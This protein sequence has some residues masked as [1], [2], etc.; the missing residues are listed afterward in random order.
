MPCFCFCGFFHVC[1]LSAEIALAFALAAGRSATAGG[2]D[3]G[4]TAPAGECPVPPA[5]GG[6]GGE[7]SSGRRRKKSGAFS[8]PLKKLCLFIRQELRILAEA[9]KVAERAQVPSPRVRARAQERGA[10]GEEPP[11]PSAHGAG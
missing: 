3:S 6:W 9:G 8:S 11:G 5:G 4:A 7:I 2:P 10:H 1:F